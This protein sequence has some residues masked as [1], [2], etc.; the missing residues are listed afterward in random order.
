MNLVDRDGACA[1]A[2]VVGACPAAPG[3]ALLPAGLANSLGLA[4]G[5]QLTFTAGVIDAPLALRVVGVYRPIDVAGPYWSVPSGSVSDPSG[6]L[7]DAVLVT[8][9]TI[10][11]ARP[12]AATVSVAMLVT[13]AGLG[14]PAQLVSTVNTVLNN[15]RGSGYAYY[16]SLGALANRVVDD[17]RLVTL[18][19]PLTA[20]EFVLLGWYALFF[21]VS[22]ASAAQRADIGLLK[23]RG[24]PRPRVWL[25]VGLR[26]AGPILLGAPIGGLI[27]YFAARAQFG[28]V[29]HP[30]RV[31]LLGLAAVLA[32]A[33]GALLAALAADRRTV[34]ADVP[35]LLRRVPPRR[36]GWRADVTDLVVVVIAVAG[37][38]QVHSSDSGLAVLAGGLVCLAA[39]L[40]L[41]R[42][43]VPV[44]ARVGAAAL[45][46]GRART[47]LTAVYLARRPGLDRV[48]ALLIVAVALSAYAVTGAVAMSSDLTHRAAVEAGAAR[49][50]QVQAANRRAL[51][52]AVRAADPTGRYA[53]AVARSAPTLGEPDVLAVDADRL[54]AVALWPGGAPRTATE[55]AA[56]LRPPADAEFV[57]AGTTLALDATV[58]APPAATAS[59]PAEGGAAGPAQPSATPSVGGQPSAQPSS[60]GQPV[61]SAA[62]GADAAVVGSLVVR[63]GLVTSGGALTSVTFGPLAAGRRSYPVTGDCAAGCRLASL[64]VGTLRSD[65]AVVVGGLD[66]A[67][68]P[69]VTLH[70]LADGAGH[71]I[72]AAQFAD[73][74]RWRPTLEP[75]AAGLVLASAADGLA[76]SSPGPVAIKI[77]TMVYPVD[78]AV[79]L[80]IV[81]SRAPDQPVSAGA[82]LL[83]PFATAALPVQVAAA[84]PEL[85][86]LGTGGALIDLDSADRLAAAAGDSGSADVLQVWL[87]GAAP[88]A[89]LT[90]LRADGVTV[91]SQD[92]LAG[93]RGRLAADA[94]VVAQRFTLFGAV[95]GLIVAACVVVLVGEVERSA[96]ADELAALRAQGLSDRAATQLGYAGYA[97]LVGAALV[98]GLLISALARALVADALAGP[99]APLDPVGLGL[100]AL[101]ALALCVPVSALLGWRLAAAVRRRPGAAR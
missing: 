76:I 27:G 75:G 71:S 55:I 14:D 72:A 16:A 4:I 49:V 91:L 63:L 46:A 29:A 21:A 85:P 54:A 67:P 15:L 22:G 2:A 81:V 39:A 51:L 48:A 9:A 84:L 23:L 77:N 1:H 45:R 97:V 41:A 28:A 58:A 3:E 8:R 31:A 52:D 98:A 64:A 18:W 65:G 86:L 82:L 40:V 60:G 17:Q 101:L 62:P 5:D 59:A 13:P 96:R 78:T 26:S 38:Y 34:R 87:T 6:H 50:L 25:L 33:L 69:T 19:V 53:M 74:A 11:D 37:V 43:L 80:P 57:L 90:R 73:R 10:V 83:A 68:L 99:V 44:A 36:R 56:L 88:A 94:A 47:A 100:G 42:L 20:V 70:G 7:A 32:A 66:A 30:V 93:T 24:A 61:G 12:S 89:V 35:D 92:T 79:P 95:L